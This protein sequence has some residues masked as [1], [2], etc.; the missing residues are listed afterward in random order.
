MVNMKMVICQELISRQY[1]Y[2][3]YVCVHYSAIQC[4]ITTIIYDRA[5]SSYNWANEDFHTS[6]IAQL[7]QRL[8]FLSCRDYN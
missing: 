5:R 8:L 1:P 2:V 4:C 6:S 7:R 3:L